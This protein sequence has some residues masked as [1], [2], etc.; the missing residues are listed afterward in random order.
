VG[1][2]LLGVMLRRGPRWPA[3]VGLI[4][5]AGVVCLVIAPIGAGGAAVWAAVGLGLVVL[6]SA[7]F[8]WLRCRPSAR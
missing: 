2:V 1:L 7:A 6:A 3:S 4:A 5:G 8:W